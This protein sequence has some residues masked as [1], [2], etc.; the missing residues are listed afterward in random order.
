MSE[1]IKLKNG[2]EFELIPMGISNDTAIKTRS[3]RF[4][5][6]LGYAETLAIVS[7][8]SNFESIQIIGADGNPQAT[9]AD[10]VSFKGL[11]FEK[12]V[13]INDTTTADVYTVTYSVDA[14]ERMLSNIN[15]QLSN[16]INRTEVTFTA[17]EWLMTI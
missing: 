1:K 14:V 12:G 6:P 7:T 15:G 2:Q 4:I 8:E 9:Y 3:F 10:C 17:V 11:A 16:N 5:S 13:K